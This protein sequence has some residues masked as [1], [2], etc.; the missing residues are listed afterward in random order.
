MNDDGNANSFY[1]EYASEQIKYIVVFS[2]NEVF[3]IVSTKR[4]RSC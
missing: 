4:W 1:D 3:G 2:E